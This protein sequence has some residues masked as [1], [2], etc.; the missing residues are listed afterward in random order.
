MAN[1]LREFLGYPDNGDSLKM[2]PEQ[3]EDMYRII[4]EPDGFSHTKN[5]LRELNKSSARL[6]IVILV[7]T[8]IG[9]IGSVVAAVCAVMLLLR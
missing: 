1:S 8:A 2:S 6:S 3:R 9:A 5:F 7:V 4:S